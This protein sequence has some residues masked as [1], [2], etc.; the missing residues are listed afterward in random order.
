[1]KRRYEDGVEG[2]IGCTDDKWRI[3]TAGLGD[4]GSIIWPEYIGMRWEVLGGS[5]G[6]GGVGGVR[7]SY[8]SLAVSGQAS[9]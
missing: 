2:N 4:I 9:Q 6:S 7:G 1:M 8:L 5:V 3:L